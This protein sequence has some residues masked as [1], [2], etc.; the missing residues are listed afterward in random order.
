MIP[1][2]D[3]H[4]TAWLMIRRYGNDAAGHAELERVDRAK[5]T[6]FRLPLWYGLEVYRSDM[7]PASWQTIRSARDA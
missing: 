6:I 1:D 4:R 5:L 2:S 7:S 3:I